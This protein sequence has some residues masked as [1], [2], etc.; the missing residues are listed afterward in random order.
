M[1]CE[2]FEQRFQEI[3]DNRQD[4]LTDAQLGEHAEYCAECQGMLQASSRLWSGL[5]E[6]IA[7][8]H[9]SVAT[10]V[11]CEVLPQTQKSVVPK[12]ALSP[13][14]LSASLI[15]L[16]LL[17][18]VPL[19]NYLAT[20]DNQPGTEQKPGIAQA[21][22]EQTP[23]GSAAPSNDSK[24][25]IAKDISRVPSGSPNFDAPFP[26]PLD[27][28]IQRFREA[29]SPAWLSEVSVSFRPVT[30]SVGSTLNVLRR[31]LPGNENPG[32]QEPQAG[33]HWDDAFLHTA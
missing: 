10:A 33:Y 19:W 6:E 27:L 23:L 30:S 22:T 8:L 11:L 29:G 3:L 13:T 32:D 20:T 21:P 17:L 25:E 12:R 18:T 26:A 16:T 28:V 15:A 24:P 4:P 9:N 31:S 5:A 1:K 14:V 7:P 2:T